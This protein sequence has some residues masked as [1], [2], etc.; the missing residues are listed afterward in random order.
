MRQLLSALLF[1]VISTIVCAD[2]VIEVKVDDVIVY[3]Q[4]LPT[5]L[6]VVVVDKIQSTT[7]TVPVNPDP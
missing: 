3:T 7:T 5:D 4:T 1:V 6:S 2:T